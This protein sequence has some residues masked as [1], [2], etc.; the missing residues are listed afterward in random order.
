VTGHLDIATVTLGDPEDTSMIAGMIYGSV[1]L[2]RG[3]DID[4]AGGSTY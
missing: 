2:R 3:G 4:L 1:I